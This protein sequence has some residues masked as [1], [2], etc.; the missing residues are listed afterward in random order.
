MSRNFRFTRNLVAAAIAVVAAGSLAT[1]ASAATP[2]NFV[3][4]ENLQASVNGNVVTITWEIPAGISDVAMWDV[5]WV[6]METGVPTGGWGIWVPGTE[7]TVT[8]TIADDTSGDGPSRISVR[9]GNGPC[10]GEGTGNCVYGPTASVDV[11]IDASAVTPVAT[12]VTVVM[13]E[14]TEAPLTAVAVEDEESDGDGDEGGNGMTIAIIV[15]GVGLIA[16]AGAI[17]SRSR[18]AKSG[19]KA[20]S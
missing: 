9:A 16:V 7:T 19:D 17:V 14:S 13:S 3:P 20:A 11:D 8:I 1:A 5:G 2:P 15:L 10:I 4:P 6:D 12:D 18:Q